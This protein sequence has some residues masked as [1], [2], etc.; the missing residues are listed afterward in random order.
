ME[1][2]HRP[3]L[4]ALAAKAEA[5]YHRIR[6]SGDQQQ[7]LD[8]AAECARIYAALGNPGKESV[9]L[10]DVG[11]C[12]VLT[13]D[14][15]AAFQTSEVLLASP[16]T[17]EDP[18]FMA[19]ALLVRA[20]ALRNQSQHVLALETARQA[21]AVLAHVRDGDRALA[22]A[23]QGIIACLVEADQ[24]HDAWAIHDKLSATLAPIDD[25]LQA[26]QGYWTLGN[27][28]FATGHEAE[29][30]AYHQLAAEQLQQINDIHLWARFNNASAD[31]QLQAGVANQRTHDNIVRAQLAYGIIGGSAVEFLGLSLTQARW[32]VAN[33]ELEEA[34][35][36]LEKA[37]ADAQVGGAP[38]DAS[39]HRM[40]SQILLALGRTDEAD[41]ENARAARIER[42]RQS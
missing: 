34:S 31:V 22:E 4:E 21:L 17:H 19:Q 27:L 3:S 10:Y 29:G 2:M 40:W 35:S 6:G 16:R 9:F 7:A 26:G 5:H 23:Y 25:P 14:Y 28:A 18:V 30:A 36:V 1:G 13:G 33:G 24:A 8:A 37:L 41:R 38:V 12:Q 15:A 11:K 39:V 42:P 20:A 32:H